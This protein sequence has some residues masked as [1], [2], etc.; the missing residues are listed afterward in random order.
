MF[1]GFSYRLRGE[2]RICIYNKKKNQKQKRINFHQPNKIPT[3]DIIMLIE[4]FNNISLYAM[5]L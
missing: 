4:N 5:Y 2:S 3:F 1:S